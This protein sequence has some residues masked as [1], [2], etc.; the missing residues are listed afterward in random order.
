MA[1]NTKFL[2]I[3]ID[4]VFD[5]TKKGWYEVFDKTKPLDL[6]GQSK[7]EDEKEVLKYKI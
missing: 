4:Y 3:S 1:M 7:A 5:G 2:M 6:Y